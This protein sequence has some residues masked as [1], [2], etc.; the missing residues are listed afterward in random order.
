VEVNYGSIGLT[1]DHIYKARSGVLKYD[2]R[3]YCVLHVTIYI[4]QGM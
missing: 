2:P 3:S 4:A 1:Y